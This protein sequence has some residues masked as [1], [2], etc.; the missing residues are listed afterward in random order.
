[1]DESERH[2]AGKARTLKLLG[3]LM[4]GATL[5]IVG[6]GQIGAMFWLLEIV[7]F[8]LVG[9]IPALLLL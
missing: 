1:M 3:S 9:F 5:A 7:A 4:A 6:W 2:A 8:V